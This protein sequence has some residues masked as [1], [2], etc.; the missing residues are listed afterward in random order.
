VRTRSNG[1]SIGTADVDAVQEM[2]VLT[3]NY[4]AE[5]GRSAGGQ[6]RIVT[7]SGQRDFHGDFYE[8]FRNSAMNANEWSRNRT[9]GREDIS[10]RPG[11]FRY[12]QFGYALSGPIFIPGKFNKDRNKLFWLWG[13]EWVKF[14][15][16]QLN[17]TGGVRVPSQAMRRGD[18]SELLGSNIYYSTPQ[19]IRDPLA[20]GAC[21]ETDRSACFPGNVIPSS[22]LSSQGLALLSAYPLPNTV[23][24]GNNFIQSRQRFDNQRKDTVSID[25]L[26]AETHYLRFRF[27]NF[28]LLHKD[29]FRT[30][31]DLAPSV[32]DRPNRTASL[33]H[34]WTV[35]PSVVNEAL[36]TASADQVRIAVD[37]EGDRYKRSVYGISYP[38]LFQQKEIFDKIPTVEIQNFNTIDGGPYP[39]SSAGP[40]YDISDNLTWIKGSHTIKFGAL[41]ERAGQN[42]FDQINVQGVPG[43]T[44]NQNGRFVFQ[45]TR[46]GGSGLAIANAALGLYDTYAELGNRSY[47]PY[48]GHMFEWFAQDSWKATSKLRFEVG[49]RFSWIQPYY[50]LWRN[51]TVFDEASYD[52]S[53]EAV[54]DPRT[55]FV[56]SG[57]QYNGLIIPG[58]GWPDAAFGRIPIADSG[59][60][61]RLFKGPKQYSETHNVWQPRIGIAYSFTD[62]TVVR[63][64]AGRFVTRLGVSDSVFLGGNPPLQPTVSTSNGRVDD[65]SGA[66]RVT[67][68][69]LSVTTQDPIFKN[70]EAWTWNFTIQRE[71]W[72]STSLE[73]GY[74]GRRG[75]HQQRE[76]NIN[77]LRTGTL[78]PTV[79][80]LADGTAINV[81][82]LRPFKGYGVIRSTN[83]DG[84]SFYNGLQVGLTRR[85]VKGLSYGFSY[86]W[87]KLL[88]DGSTQRSI[89]PD[90]Y[91]DSWMW[92]AANY[93]RRHVAVLNA[94]Y[95][96][97][98]LRQQTTPL[99][100][101]LGGWQISLVAQFQTGTP[102][103]VGTT[104]D[105]AGVGPGSGNTNEGIPATPWNIVGDAHV[106][107]PKF[108]EGAADQNFYFNPRA[109]VKPAPGTFSNS[110]FRNRMYNPGFQN[111]TGAL[112]K[113]FGITE[114]HKLTFRSEFYNFP[115]HPNWSNADTNPQSGT[116]GKVTSKTFERTIQLSLRYSF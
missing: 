116:F 27:Q 22:R 2:Q 115:N 77:Q 8:Y 6:I 42:D 51:M 21:N 105:N 40:I 32:L 54:L 9:L 58:S 102:F 106:S 25:Y 13:Q 31:L 26:P 10:G 96:L 36:V 81:D 52:R 11:P 44:N 80:R 50:S 43:G 35:S 24:G 82:Y 55:G 94:V 46:P 79:P 113:T 101:L 14:R 73:V 69:P 45:D 100:K 89:L 38:Y 88:D 107:D 7:K 75:L 60:F 98:F 18:F 112:F 33:N 72:G 15:Q 67:G 3:A 114:T 61:D 1:T 57:D 39:S 62:K 30:N 97:P 109:F 104:D 84:S 108:S 5:Y 74:V 28:S 68:F 63:A 83:N 76:R 41:W 4:N 70:P 16:D 56:I 37:T 12:N 103:W 85:F 53:R 19:Y 87:S 99:G 78:Q 71:L 65:P 110:R 111:W 34:I 49:L 66:G 17:Q 48:R 95:E 91:N 86:T 59:E 20:T 47:T 23:L 29:A 64:G 90:A 93:D 92:G